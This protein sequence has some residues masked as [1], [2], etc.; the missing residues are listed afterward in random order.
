VSRLV[1]WNQAIEVD[2]YATDGWILYPGWNTITL[3]LSELERPMSNDPHPA[4]RLWRDMGQVLHFRIDPLEVSMDTRF[5]IDEVRLLSDP[6]VHGSFPANLG[7]SD[8]QGQP[9][10]VRY[11]YD[12]DG[13]GFNGQEF[14]VSDFATG[15]AE[16]APSGHVVYMPWVALNPQPI[17]PLL[18][19]GPGLSR[20][21]SDV[22]VSFLDDGTYY[23][24]ACASDGISQTCAY[25]PEPVSV[26]N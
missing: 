17:L 9:I 7:V 12:T 4:N 19:D 23:F 20:V 3:D 5:H 14:P 25:L 21:S 24:Y 18:P 22:D 15:P 16:Q 6:V 8:P 10:I 1:W 2:G 11:Y 13:Y 26:S